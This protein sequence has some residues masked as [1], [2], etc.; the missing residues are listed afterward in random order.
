MLAIGKDVANAL[1]YGLLSGGQHLR[2]ANWAAVCL[3]VA[4]W[5]LVQGQQNDAVST[6]AKP[7][8]MSIARL[9]SEVKHTF[10]C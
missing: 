7:V 10:A 8:L 9:M 1:T 3:G 2:G 6:A 5:G 4:V